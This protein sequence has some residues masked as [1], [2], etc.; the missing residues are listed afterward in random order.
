MLA[1]MTTE[2]LLPAGFTTRPATMDDLETAVTLMNICSTAQVGRPEHNTADTTLEWTQEKFNLA[3]NTHL[4]FAPNGEMVGYL[5]IWDIH[6][7]PVS[8]WVWG[9]VHPDYEGLGIGTYMLTW[10]EEQL[11]RTFD[12]VPA[13]ARVVFRSG[14]VSTYEPA[15]QLLAGYG[16][17]PVRYFWKMLIDFDA[18]PPYPTPPEGITIKPFTAVNDL[19]AV[20]RATDEAFHDHWGY[21]E[22]PEEE[23]LKEWQEWTKKDSKHDPGLWFLAMDGDEIAG[24]SLCRIEDW[25]NAEWGHVDELAVRR[26]WRRRGIALALLHHSFAALYARGKKSVSLGVDASSLTGA[27]RLY[28]KAGM[29]IFREFQTFEKELRPGRDLS[30][31]TLE[32]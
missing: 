23:M 8:N 18:Q 20:M 25:N 27:T 21:V 3:T 10:T 1:E 13:D 29:R 2:Q 9:C 6:P 4:V 28:E 12:R 16:M 24:V 15:Q 31:Q 30:R 7:V 11:Q 22:Q 19:T 17:T 26:P 32:E 5:E 14:A